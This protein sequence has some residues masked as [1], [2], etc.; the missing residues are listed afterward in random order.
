MRPNF[1]SLPSFPPNL[2]CLLML[3]IFLLVGPYALLAAQR[4]EEYVTDN[5]ANSATDGASYI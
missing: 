5:Y 1:P 4:V 3:F 2:A